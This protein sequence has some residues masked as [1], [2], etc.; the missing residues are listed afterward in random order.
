MTASTVFGNVDIEVAPTFFD[1]TLALEKL[2]QGEIAGMVYVVGKPA[3]LFQGLKV[4][5]GLHFIPVP[6]TAAFA[7]T[8]L[9]SQ[10][11]AEDYP[12]LIPPD[13]RVNTVAVSTVL[14]VLNWRPDSPRYRKIAR[15]VDAF[16]SHF[17]VFQKSQRHKIRTAVSLT[18]GILGWTRFEA[19]E[20]W[21]Q[22][23]TSTPEAKLRTTVMQF[24]SGTTPAA[25]RSPW[26]V[27]QNTKTSE[28]ERRKTFMQFLSGVTPAADQSPSNVKQ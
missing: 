19:A 27:K 13:S 24:L 26:Q 11:T 4:E 23:N 17:T 14:A 25:D 8:Y 6:I 21:L 22:Q 2:K 18:A 9:T 20:D 15:F 12:A 16:F 7:D 3:Q 28:E 1:Q 10:L 5:G